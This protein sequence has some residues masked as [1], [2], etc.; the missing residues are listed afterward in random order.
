MSVEGELMYID[1]NIAMWVILIAASGCA[2]M[3]GKSYGNR[4]RETIIEDT[5]TYL[6]ENNFVR[7]RLIDGEHE[8]IQ[9]DED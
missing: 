7:S 3:A 9:L 2:F 1:P 5:I 6:V 4:E 8:L